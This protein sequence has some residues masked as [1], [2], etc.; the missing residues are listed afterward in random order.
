MDAP[1]EMLSSVTLDPTIAILIVFL[2]VYL[3]MASALAFPIGSSIPDA[4]A[5]CYGSP[6]AVR[7]GFNGERILFGGGSFSCTRSA[8]SYQGSFANNFAAALGFFAILLAVTL[9]KM[10]LLSLSEIALPILYT[11]FDSIV[12]GFR[13]FVFLLL[14]AKNILT[15]SLQLLHFVLLTPWRLYVIGFE[16]FRALPFLGPPPARILNT[17]LGR[18]ECLECFG[19]HF[20]L[21]TSH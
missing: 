18:H 7:V 6:E 9:S 13:L 3:S 20:G 4:H 19:V 8:N 17:F 11:Y 5:H 12:F 15:I 10:L 1:V 14:L 16:F 21:F 2:G